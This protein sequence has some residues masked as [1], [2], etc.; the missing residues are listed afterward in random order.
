[1]KNARSLLAY[2]LVA[3]VISFSVGGENVV[4]SETSI[5]QNERSD[6]YFSEHSSINSL[7]VQP[8][9]STIA[10][11]FVAKQVLSSFLL[12]KAVLLLPTPQYHSTLCVARSL[13]VQ[14]RR[15]AYVIYPFHDFL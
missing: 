10:G 6:A 12:S 9:V 11:H 13:S 1:M 14:Q 4:F 3:L 5:A 15:V 7:F 8:T 2:I